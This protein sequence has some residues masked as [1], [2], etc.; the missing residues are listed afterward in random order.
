[1]PQGPLQ[2]AGLNYTSQLPAS[3]VPV[4]PGALVEVQPVSGATKRNKV[5]ASDLVTG[6]IAIGLTAVGTSRSNALALVKKQN[7]VAT[8]ASSA[9]G[10]VLP[11][12][13]AVGIGNWV[14]VY[15][16]GPANSF[17][18]YAAGSD[19]IDGAAGST[20]VVLT[21]AFW[22]RYLVSDTGKFVS[23]RSAITR[24]A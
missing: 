14:D 3:A 4:A 1:M 18:V 13:S 19:T 6:G 5:A 24:S 12:A 16:D 10:V 9:V 17:H 23:Y 8:A 20:G 15:N 11:A 7:I 21:N 22:C 2:V